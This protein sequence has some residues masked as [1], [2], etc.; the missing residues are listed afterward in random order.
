MYKLSVAIAEKLFSDDMFDGLLYPTVQM[1][2]NADNLA[3]KPRYADSHLK[4]LKAEFARINAV[5]EIALDI[6]VLDTAVEL[7]ADG[8]IV[9]RGRRD[10]WVLREQGDQ[11]TLSVENGRWVARDNIGRIV[12]PE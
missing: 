2:A 4:F 3:I 12:D 5:R 10:Q 11:L 1:Q 6:D 7:E 8:K 9:W